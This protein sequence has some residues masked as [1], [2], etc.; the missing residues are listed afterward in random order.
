MQSGKIKILE[1]LFFFFPIGMGLSRNWKS[2]KASGLE[3]WNR[4]KVWTLRW[5]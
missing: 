3:T 2:N 5:D 1:N 4:C